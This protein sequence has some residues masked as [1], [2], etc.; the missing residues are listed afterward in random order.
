MV[1]S[2]PEFGANKERTLEPSQV[3]VHEGVYDGVHDTRLTETMKKILVLL[4]ETKSTSQLLL[5]L[6]YSQRTRNY[7]G[8]ITSL[9]DSDL[10]EMTLPDT[11]RSKNQQYRLTT[12]FFY[13]LVSI[14]SCGLL[15]FKTQP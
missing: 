9:L 5:Q 14:M 10:I 13:S 11:P 6:G 15:F 1:I 4:V 3:G 7:E 2:V 12:I 8:A